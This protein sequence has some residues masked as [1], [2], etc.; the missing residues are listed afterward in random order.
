[1]NEFNPNEL[2]EINY[3]KKNRDNFFALMALLLVLIPL[4][5][6]IIT[7]LIRFVYTTVFDNY[8]FES[9]IY[10]FFIVVLLVCELAI[11]ILIASKT[12]NEGIKVAVIILGIVLFVYSS[13]QIFGV[14]NMF[15]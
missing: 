14:F 11:P 5:R 15:Y 9:I 1:M 6:I 3:K 12:R 13:L 8:F 4:A 10:K 2:D 7:W